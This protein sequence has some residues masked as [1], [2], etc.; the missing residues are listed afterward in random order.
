[1]PIGVADVARLQVTPQELPNSGESGAPKI[2]HGVGQKGAAFRLK[3]GTTNT[4]ADVC[5]T[6]FRAWRT[7]SFNRRACSAQW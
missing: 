6:A 5:R 4:R 7:Y 2:R 3:L 1:M